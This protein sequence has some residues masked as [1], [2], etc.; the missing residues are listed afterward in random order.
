QAAVATLAGGTA[1]IGVGF[2]GFVLCLLRGFIGPVSDL[3]CFLFHPVLRLLRALR[4]AVPAFSGFLSHLVARFLDFAR[5]SVCHGFYPHEGDSPG[6]GS[7]TAS[8]ETGIG[9]M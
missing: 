7:D 3:V 9:E 1:G 8:P 4:D 2:L 6:G 5:N